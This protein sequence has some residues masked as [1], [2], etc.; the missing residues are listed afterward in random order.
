[1]LP[2]D[3]SS[4]CKYN[5]TGRVKGE[6]S[7]DAVPQNSRRH[8]IGSMNKKNMSQIRKFRWNKIMSK[9]ASLW[10]FNKNENKIDSK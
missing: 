10:K 4:F 3:I 5:I 6:V 7:A 1:M 8:N 9:I 2:R